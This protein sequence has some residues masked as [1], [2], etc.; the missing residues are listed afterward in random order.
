MLNKYVLMTKWMKLRLKILLSLLVIKQVRTKGWDTIHVA[1]KLALFL[2]VHT[3]DNTVR[4]RHCPVLRCVWFRK[5][6]L[7]RD[8]V[9]LPAP[10]C[11]VADAAKVVGL[12]A[13]PSLLF[14][15][16]A[17]EQRSEEDWPWSCSSPWKC[18][19]PV[20]LGVLRA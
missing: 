16:P 2:T 10:E 11:C 1:P 5:E 18:L 12:P 7:T 14:T 3:R 15:T 9:S 19:Q 17:M 8:Y 20:K 4:S 6:N 13:F